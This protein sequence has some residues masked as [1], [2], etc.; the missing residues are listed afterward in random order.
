MSK[1]TL[2][3]QA[4]DRKKLYSICKAINIHLLDRGAKK[5]RDKRQK[6]NEFCE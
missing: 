5:N 2:L 6:S 3:D 4:G 1:N